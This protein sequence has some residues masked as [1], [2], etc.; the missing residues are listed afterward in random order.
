M[1]NTS[2]FSSASGMNDAGVISWPPRIQRISAS[3]PVTRPVLA[4]TIGW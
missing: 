3:A 4:S 2:P 1:R